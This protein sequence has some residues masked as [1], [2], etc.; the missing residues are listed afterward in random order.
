MSFGTPA[1]TSLVLHLARRATRDHTAPRR[2]VTKRPPAQRAGLEVRH[3]S[4]IR[5][6]EGQ[7]VRAFVMSVMSWLATMRQS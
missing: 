3:P 2:H 1:P 7:R 5:L 6:F 4:K